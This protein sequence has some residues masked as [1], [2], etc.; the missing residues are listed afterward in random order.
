MIVLNA[1]SG[2]EAER[3]VNQDNKITIDCKSDRK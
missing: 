1:A 3:V 2:H